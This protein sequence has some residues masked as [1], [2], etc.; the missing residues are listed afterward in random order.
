MKIQAVIDMEALGAQFAML[1]VNVSRTTAIS[2][3]S[4]IIK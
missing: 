2:R 3:S 1:E 4:T